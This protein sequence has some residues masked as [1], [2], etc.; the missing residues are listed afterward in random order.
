M[1]R[2]IPLALAVCFAFSGCSQ[3]RAQFELSS[4]AIV[5]GGELPVTYTCDG[6]SVSPPIDWTGEPDGTVSFAVLMDH[7]P[8]PGDWHW[9]WT[10]WDIPSSTHHLDVD[11]R[12]VGIAGTNSVNDL[13]GYAPPCSKG[14]GAKTYTI[15]VFALSANAN[16]PDASSVDRETLLTSLADITLATDTLTFTYTRG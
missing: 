5:D 11:S 12:G 3:G 7:Q 13:L 2:V 10:M 9:Y 14:P 16:L 6:D 1:R 15:T 4:P 8:G